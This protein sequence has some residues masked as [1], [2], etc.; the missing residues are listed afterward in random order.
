MKPGPNNDPLHPPEKESA[1]AASRVFEFTH[2]GDPERLDIVLSEQVPDCSRA[3]IKRLIDEGYVTLSPLLRPLKASRKLPPGTKVRL[4]IPPPRKVDLSPQDIP[5]EVLYEDDHLAVINKPAGLTVHPAPHET[6]P[7][8]VNALL[9]KLNGLSSIGGEE[10]PGIVHRL[11]KETS[12]VLVVAKND[13]AHNGI[14]S[15]FKERTVHKTY[16]AVVRG[17]PQDDEGRINLP[18]GK[19]YTQSKQQMIRVDGSG[20]EALTDFRVLEKYRGYAFLEVKPHTGRT[21]QIRVHLLNAHVPVACDK[22]YGRETAIYASQL[23]QQA[24]PPAEAPL[25]ARHA[26]HATTLSFRHPHTGEILN[27]TAKLPADMQ[28]LL[29]ALN[30]YRVHR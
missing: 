2:A 13:A 25:I 9:F 19:S 14:S 26:L 29:K 27:F 8:L 23:S 10:R 15:Q 20:R 22:L 6:A 30:R 18:L 7:T 5:L 16:L 24:R 12:G 28:A 11:D 3:H 17:E 1:S 21:H 4:V